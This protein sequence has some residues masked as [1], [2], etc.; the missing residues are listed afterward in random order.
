MVLDRGLLVTAATS[1]LTWGIILAYAI[2][3]PL[4]IALAAGARRLRATAF[5]AGVGFTVSLLIAS[6]VFEGAQLDQAR[7]GILV[8][9][10]LAPALAVASTAR[11]RRVSTCTAS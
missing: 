2:G 5:S 1:S 10:L 7:V 3:K 4:G 11:V 8:T 9:A 6:R